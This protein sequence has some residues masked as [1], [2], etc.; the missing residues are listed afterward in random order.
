MPRSGLR[1]RVTWKRPGL[2][3]P[4]ILLGVAALAI[5]SLPMLQRMRSPMAKA[6]VLAVPAPIDGDRAFGYLRAICKLGP[7]PAGSPANT[8]Q[9]EMVARHFEAMGG[10]RPRA[11]IRRRRPAQRRPGRDGQPHRLLASRASR[12]G[13]ARR[14]LRHPPVPRRGARSVTPPPPVPGRQRR[15]LGRGPADGDRASPERPEEPLGDRPRPLR[16]RRTGLRPGRRVLPRLQGVRAKLCRDPRGGRFA[17]VR[18]RPGARHGRRPQP[19]DRSGAA[20]PRARPPARPGRLG[21][22]PDA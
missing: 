5:L 13:P 22:R 10:G 11:A 16:R 18:R 9:R 6:G 15:R 12:T 14:P 2:R 21:G 8:R 7:R 17:G 20:Q 4:L 19:R 1:E 3:L